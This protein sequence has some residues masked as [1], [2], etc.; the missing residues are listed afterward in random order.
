MPPV[1]V[2]G[3]G[4]DV[5]P[6]GHHGAVLNS[7]PPFDST[8]SLPAD[9]LDP[10]DLADLADP[11]AGVVAV[12]LSRRFVRLCLCWAE[13]MVGELAAR[14]ALLRRPGGP[15][16]MERVL[17]QRFHRRLE[18]EVYAQ[19]SHCVPLA[20]AAAALAAAEELLRSQ[21]GVV[22]EIATVHLLEQGRNAAIQMMAVATTVAGRDVRAGLAEVL[23]ANRS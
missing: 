4:A 18:S 14:E 11:V 16:L 7:T 22:V 6:P 1:R 20:H 9:G 19:F 10:A 5:G 15:E 12:E 23:V 17:T 3:I 2:I 13:P 8:P 21:F